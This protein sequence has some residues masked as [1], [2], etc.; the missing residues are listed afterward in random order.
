LGIYFK[1]IS[2]GKDEEALKIGI[3]ECL[4]MIGSFILPP[5]CFVDILKKLVFLLPILQTSPDINIYSFENGEISGIGLNLLILTLSG[6]FYLTICIMIDMKIFQKI[7]NLLHVKDQKFPSRGNIDSDVLA[8]IERVD[9]MTE[10]ESSNSNLV[11]KNLSKLYGN[12]L[13]VNQLSFSIE[14]SECFG[15]LGNFFK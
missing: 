10:L 4:Y 13:A 1:A 3:L 2:R 12:F 14:Q 6:C 5:F 9:S 7:L 8:E 15:L 11:V